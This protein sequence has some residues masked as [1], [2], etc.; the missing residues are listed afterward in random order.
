[1]F[2]AYR[3]LQAKTI[4]RFVFYTFWR[5]KLRSVCSV[6]LADHSLYYLRSR[7]GFLSHCLNRIACQ[8]YMCLDRIMFIR[9]RLTTARARKQSMLKTRMRR[10]TL[11]SR[12]RTNVRSS[13]L[14]SS[15]KFVP[16]FSEVC[17]CSF[18]S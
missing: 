15:E 1:M 18:V 17:V 7:S 11:R 10:E 5:G 2:L 9:N 14:L 13:F 12:S 4:V 6:D 16:D 8:E 3:I